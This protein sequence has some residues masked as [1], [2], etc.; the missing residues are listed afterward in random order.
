MVDAMVDL[1]CHNGNIFMV[2]MVDDVRVF[3]SINCDVP[4]FGY[5]SEVQPP[6]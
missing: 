6:D 5:P 2:D 3:R 1:Y 4:S